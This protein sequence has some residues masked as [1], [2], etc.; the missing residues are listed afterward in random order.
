V[1][2]AP[3]GQKATATDERAA[4]EKIV[5]EVAGGSQV[6]RDDATENE[7]GERTSASG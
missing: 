1:F 5:T 4:V 7:N 6:A 2:G 3:N